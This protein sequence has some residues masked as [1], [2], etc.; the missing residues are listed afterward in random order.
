MI[1]NWQKII[2]NRLI[3]KYERTSAYRE[4]KVPDKRIF[5]KFYGNTKT[6]FPE[7]D[8]ESRITRISINSAVIEL[9]EKDMIFFEWMRGEDNHIISRVWLNFDTVENIYKFLERRSSKNVIEEVCVEI[10]AEI[11]KSKTQWITDYYKDTLV[12]MRSHLSTGN[13]LPKSIVD[14]ENIYKVMQFI[15]NNPDAVFS[16]RVFSEKCFGDSKF[17]ESQIKSTLLSILRKYLDS[18]SNDN[19]LLSMIGIVKYPE[20][21][22]LCGNF[23]LYRTDKKYDFADLKTGVCIYSSDID[24][25]DLFIDKSIR[26]IITIENRANYFTYINQMKSSDELV[27]YHAGHYSPSKKK[28]LKSLNKAMSGNCIWLHWGDIDFGG[29]SMLKRLR[30][31][32]NINILPY[33]MNN[34]ELVKFSSYTISF[35]DEYALKLKNLLDE[36]I[37]FDCKACLEYMLKNKVRLEQEAMLTNLRK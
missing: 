6:D 37:L 7:Y 22:E 27:V 13:R 9:C 33:R 30:Q 31:E 11:E 23:Y 12:F 21:L 10:C 24:D 26:K 2:L 5:L 18:N 8:I 15:D 19:D 20:Q 35:S 1:N 3:D 34:E 36:E 25:F 14:R 32:I 16:E 29:F 28:L 4:G 17:F